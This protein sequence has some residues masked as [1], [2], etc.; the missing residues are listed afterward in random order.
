MESVHKKF[1]KFPAHRNGKGEHKAEYRRQRWGAGALFALDNAGE[2]VAED[3]AHEAR[4]NVREII[5]PPEFIEKFQIRAENDPRENDDIQHRLGKGR[6]LLYERAVTEHLK[7]IPKMGEN[8]AEYGFKAHNEIAVYEGIGGAYEHGYSYDYPKGELRL[9]YFLNW[10]FFY[11]I[12][13]NM[14]WTSLF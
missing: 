4:H 13:H 6:H 14:L 1:V 5:K 9:G 11:F 10:V 2:I 3:G 7:H 8:E 12:G